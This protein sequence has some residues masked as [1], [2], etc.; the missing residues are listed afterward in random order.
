[1]IASNKA[2]Q[3]LLAIQKIAIAARC[4]AGDK[5]V[6][7]LFNLLDDLEYLP[8]LILENKDN[9]IEFH[10]YLQHMSQRFPK[11][12]RALAAYESEIPENCPAFPF[13]EQKKAT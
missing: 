2:S 12:R 3:A 4:Y 9:T 7:L 5:E 11:V 13:V 10:R 6:D 8:A 1:M